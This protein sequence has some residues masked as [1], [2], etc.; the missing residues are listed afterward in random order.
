MSSTGGSINKSQA[1]NVYFGAGFPV[2]SPYLKE[3][4]TYF[5]TDN[6]LSSGVVL[7]EFVWDSSGWIQAPTN[8]A[9]SPP[10]WSN[11]SW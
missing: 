5:Q 10:A 9:V 11:V 2:A 6:G 1:S 4:D 8:G 3:N 7:L